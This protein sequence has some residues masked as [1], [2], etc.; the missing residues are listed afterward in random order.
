MILRSITV[1][2]IILA[3]ASA[4]AVTQDDYNRAACAGILAHLANVNLTFNDLGARA[5]GL[6]I[7]DLIEGIDPTAL[8]GL[9]Y[10]ARMVS[11]GDYGE[12]MCG[13][14]LEECVFVSTGESC[15]TIRRYLDQ[16]R[17]EPAPA[18]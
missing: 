16:A 11:E 10:G 13:R 3:P 18:R 9:A 2:A 5:F 17:G 6:A 15:P 14:Y 1:A 4:L 12:W 7:L 8:A